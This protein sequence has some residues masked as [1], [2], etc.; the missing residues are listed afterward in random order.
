[1]FGNLKDSDSYGLI[2]RTLEYIFNRKK[3]G[4][5]ITCSIL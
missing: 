4:D 2:P 3:D 1:M 5:V